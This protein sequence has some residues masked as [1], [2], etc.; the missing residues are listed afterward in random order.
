MFA[1]ITGFTSCSSNRNP[2]DVLQLLELLF[3]EFYIV[4]L[5][6]GVFKVSTIGECY[7]MTSGL[8]DIR[9]DHAEVMAKFSVKWQKI[10]ELVTTELSYTLGSETTYLKLRCG[11]HSG[12]VTA[13]VLWG[14]RSI[15]EIFGNTVNTASRIESTG[16]PTR[17]QLSQATTDLLI[18]AGKE[19]W[20]KPRDS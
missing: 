7:L 18:K 4:G 5:Q 6:T 8:P 15:F 17:I 12:P 19:S 3:K 10:F 14:I 11:L 16:I 2:V 20:V 1:D 13:G 9:D